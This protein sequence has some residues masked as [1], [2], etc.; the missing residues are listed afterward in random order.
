MSGSKY[1]PNNFFMKGWH[2]FFDLYEIDEH[3]IRIHCVLLPQATRELFFT[4]HKIF[5]KIAS[6][7]K[8]TILILVLYVSHR[9]E[10]G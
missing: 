4:R 5:F 6:S 9:N 1:Q 8:A 7:S 3:K 10:K 2:F